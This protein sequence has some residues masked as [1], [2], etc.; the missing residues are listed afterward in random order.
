MGSEE[1]ME[2]VR[3]VKARYEQKLMRLPNVIGVG[4]GLREVGG[5]IT[6]QVALSVLVSHKVPLEQLR[7]RDRIPGELDGV[8]VDVR[9]VGTFRAQEE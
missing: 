2:R 7:P 6:D 3:A 4:I 5:Q 1:E 8:P 9:E